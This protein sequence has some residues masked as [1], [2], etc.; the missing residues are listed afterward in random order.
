MTNTPTSEAKLRVATYNVHGCV[1]MDRRRSEARIAE[2]IAEMS[3][4]IVALQELDLGR[5]RSAGADQ[6]KMIAEQLGWH[7]HFHPAMRRDDEHYGNAI[8]SRYQLSFR[9]AVE[10]PGRPPF[11]CRENR[12]AIEVEHRNQSREGPH[13]QHASRSRLARTPRSSTTVYQPPSGAQQSPATHRSSCSAISTV[14]AV[15]NPIAHLTAI[16]AMCANS[17]EATGPIGTFPTRFPMLAVDH[18]FVNGAVEP[19]T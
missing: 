8:L 3:V 16:C 11:F 4:D 1:G 13:H 18:I 12:A 7:R 6:T 14:C 2:V 17:F 5:R 9:R 15:R 10:L 19:L